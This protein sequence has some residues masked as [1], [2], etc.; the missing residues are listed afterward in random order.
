MQQL[1]SMDGPVARVMN[2]I[3][4][5]IC[6]S[7]LLVLCSVPIFTAGAAFT[8]AYYTVVKT[9]RHHV[10]HTFREFFSSFKTNFKQATTT[11]VIHLG[12]LVLLIAEC[13]F[14]FGNQ[15]E[16]SLTIV[17]LIYLLIALVIANGMYYYPCLSRFIMTKVQLLKASILLMFRYLYITVLLLVL[18]VAVIIGIYLIPLGL[19]VFPG[20]A[21]YGASFVMEPVLRKMM[22]E[23]EEGSEEAEKWYYQ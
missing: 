3:W 2:T 10:G 15:E 5:L 7:F 19:F 17:Y 22:P 20:L 12:L 1:F 4:E 16:G 13:T 6:V 9:V 8:A 14:F 11:W 23:P 21:I 18:L